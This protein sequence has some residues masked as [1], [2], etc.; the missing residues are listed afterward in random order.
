[1]QKIGEGIGMSFGMVDGVF[2]ITSNAV[3]TT[4]LAAVLLM[5]GFWIKSKVKFL[6]K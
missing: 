5:I 2:T 3:M 4:A 1:M 6:N